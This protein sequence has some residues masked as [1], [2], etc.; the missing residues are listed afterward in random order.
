MN[1]VEKRRIELG[2]SSEER[3]QILEGITKDD[4]VVSYVTSAVKEGAVVVP[5]DEDQM[6]S[7]LGGMGGLEDTGITV[8][9]N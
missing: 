6:N 4:K 2:I 5:V 1:M 3:S 7:L 9:V 8:N